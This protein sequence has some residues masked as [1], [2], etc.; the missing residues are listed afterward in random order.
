MGWIWK[1]I[2]EAV[3]PGLRFWVVA[4]VLACISLILAWLDG[5]FS[6]DI[7]KLPLPWQVLISEVLGVRIALAIAAAAFAVAG[8]LVPALAFAV[9]D[10]K[11]KV[12]TA[13]ESGLAKLG[14][15][16]AES[17]IGGD[18]R[19]RIDVLS[20]LVDASTLSQSQYK[21][22]VWRLQRKR[23]KNLDE[24]DWEYFDFVND[25]FLDLVYDSKPIFREEF[26]STVMLH[27]TNDDDLYNDGRVIRN[28]GYLRWER[29]ISYYVR[30]LRDQC[31]EEIITQTSNVIDQSVLRLALKHVK[32][33][34]EIKDHDQISL[35][36]WEI[37]RVIKPTDAEENARRLISDGNIDGTAE[38]KGHK[39][40]YR[41]TYNVEESGDPVLDLRIMIPWE[42]GRQR[43]WV[44]GWEHHLLRR[45]ENFYHL[46][47]RHP[48]KGIHAQMRLGKGLDSWSL[49]E[50]TL[51]PHKYPKGLGRCVADGGESAHAGVRQ[52]DYVDVKLPTWV[53]PGIALLKEWRYPMTDRIFSG[54]L[55]PAVS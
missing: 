1:R 51:A 5:A 27:E 31:R 15:R 47:I 33:G 30:S 3:G 22:I 29:Q 44:R 49:L 54:T 8:L 32:F 6:V 21:D 7:Q 42:L 28:L 39:I 35:L 19:K 26:V 16:I 53:L 41:M 34:L 2:K 20:H 13:V 55:R 12:S 46:N 14:D 50:P 43:A 37:G 11:D 17:L 45:D 18:A 9:S 52:R 4:A 38:Y 25:N 24:D 10:S 48:T 23:F 40:I 36:N